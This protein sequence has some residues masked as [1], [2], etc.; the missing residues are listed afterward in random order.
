MPPKSRKPL[1]EQSTNKVTPV[2]PPTTSPFSKAG[3]LSEEDFAAYPIRLY[4]LVI[5]GHANCKPIPRYVII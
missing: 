3:A 2:P 5:I 4:P 1:A